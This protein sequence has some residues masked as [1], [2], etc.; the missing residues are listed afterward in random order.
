MVKN[1]T[2]DWYDDIYE[3]GEIKSKLDTVGNI[4]NE[5][6]M[7]R[8]TYLNSLAVQPNQYENT[9]KREK[10][11]TKVLGVKWLD[12]GRNIK[13]KL[14]VLNQDEDLINKDTVYP[15]TA[16]VGINSEDL[17][18]SIKVKGTKSTHRNSNN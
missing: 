14:E 11:W 4:R 9:N 15:V 7:L 6:F 8:N 16:H 5:D 17:K 10:K 2:K 12:S 3:K 18:S 13:T 1:Q